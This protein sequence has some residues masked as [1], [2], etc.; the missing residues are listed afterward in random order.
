MTWYHH[1]N[2][3]CYFS[4]N[5]DL[6]YYLTKEFFGG[7]FY[8]YVA[9]QFSVT[10]PPSS[11]PYELHARLCRASHSRDRGDANIL[12]IKAVLRSVALVKRASNIIDD[13]QL[14]DILDTLDMAQPEDYSPLIYVI[15]RS[16]IDP[17][18]LKSVPVKQ[19][20]HFSSRELR[21]EDLQEHEFVIIGTDCL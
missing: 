21:I 7:N 11:Q 16:A 17:S 20:P 9:P 1:E 8:V 14:Q 4:V 3:L 12:R 6:V 10:N 18:R 19:R 2:D 15:P 13:S 5:A